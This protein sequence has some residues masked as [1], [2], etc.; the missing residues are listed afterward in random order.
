MPLQRSPAAMRAPLVNLCSNGSRQPPAIT[1]AQGTLHLMPYSRFLEQ[2]RGA[3]SREALSC[4]FHT[5]E[6]LLAANQTTGRHTTSTPPKSSNALIEAAPKQDE[7]SPYAPWSDL[8]L[9]YPRYPYTSELIRLG[10]LNGDLAM[11]RKPTSLT[12][13]HEPAGD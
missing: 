1:V 5:P 12:V 3:P 7:I 8:A 9:F 6:T 4:G 13:Q 11:A 2:S 10:D